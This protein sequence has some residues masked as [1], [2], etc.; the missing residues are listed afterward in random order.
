MVG[1]T[2]HSNAGNALSRASLQ[3][4]EFYV[5][6][7]ICWRRVERGVSVRREIVCNYE[8]LEGRRT[9]LLELSASLR[10]ESA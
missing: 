5:R 10:G 3:K 8:F 4:R 7:T 6:L 1:V 2:L 9:L